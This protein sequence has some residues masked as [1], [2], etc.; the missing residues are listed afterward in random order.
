MKEFVCGIAL[1]WGD[2]EANAAGV[3]AWRS[4]SHGIRRGL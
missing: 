2:M 4:S 1:R 3:P